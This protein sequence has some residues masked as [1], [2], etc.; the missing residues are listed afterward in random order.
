MEEG[1]EKDRFPNADD[2]RRQK[3]KAKWG[4][5]LVMGGVLAEI[6]LGFAFARKEDLEMA[7]KDPRKRLI[8]SVRAVVTLEVSGTNRIPFDLSNSRDHEFVWLQLGRS[9]LTKS[10]NW[11]VLLVCKDSQEWRAGEPLRSV[12]DLE[13]GPPLL[14]P[15]VIFGANQTVEMAD[16]WDNVV[17]H[18]PFF[19]RDSEVLRGNAT[20]FINWERKEYP[21][22]PQKATYT[23][24]NPLPL[25][26]ASN[27]VGVRVSTLPFKLQ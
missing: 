24:G 13:F 6:V 4:R 25:I 15:R 18:A 14:T 1:E 16:K 22:P 20:V 3:R 21:I 19:P 27:N 26:G 2:L 10:N 5:W 23:G 12:W 8:E 11:D 17:L 7:K 9:E